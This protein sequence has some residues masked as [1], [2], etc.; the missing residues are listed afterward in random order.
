V[1]VPATSANLGPAFDAAGIALTLHD[2][3]EVEVTTGGCHVEV[4][5][6]GAGTVPG[7]ESH[8][9][10]RALRS[11]LEY[12]GVEQPG[13]RLRAVNR[14][15]HGRG[16]GSSA[17]AT[18]AG[19]LA[20]H[21]LLA[22]VPGHHLDD[23][24]VLTLATRFEGHADNVGATLMG[25][26]TL[27]WESEGVVNAHR[28]A[29]HPDVE[30]LVLVPQETLSTSRARGLLPA[31]VPHRAAAFNAGRA[32]LLVT[33]LGTRPDLLLPATDDRLHQP[34][35]AGA[36]PE[37][38]TLLARLR[39]DGH[40]AVISGA[41]PSVLVLGAAST[42]ESVDPGENWSKHLLRID[43]HG[44]RVLRNPRA[45]GTRHRA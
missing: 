35:R 16:L 6:E 43:G 38:M 42:L 31:S 11:G 32:A 30:A 15:P 21:D 7:D 25:G 13:I 8:L 24:H 36:F 26:L 39:R 14:I 3:V 2:D 18:V 19:L 28:T 4:V 41:G 29:V 12:A 17:A 45:V 44:A 23:A 40:A 10:V 1:R 5:G 22:H 37:S 34:Y 33:A 27:V 9:V 20:A